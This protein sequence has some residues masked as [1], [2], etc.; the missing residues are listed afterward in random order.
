MFEVRFRNLSSGATNEKT[1]ALSCKC[2]NGGDAHEKD[3]GSSGDRRH[4]WCHRCERAG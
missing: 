2:S 4:A 3:I 1:S